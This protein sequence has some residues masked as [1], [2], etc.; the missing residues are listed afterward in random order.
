MPHTHT[1]Y[2]KEHSSGLTFV[3]SSNTSFCA[4]LHVAQLSVHYPQQVHLDEANPGLIPLKCMSGF[5]KRSYPLPV[6]S[7]QQSHV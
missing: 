6:M 1:K 3:C 4:G 2:R 7:P 5:G